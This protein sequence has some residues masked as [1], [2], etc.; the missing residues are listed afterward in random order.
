M[1]VRQAFL[2]YMLLLQ[3]TILMDELRITSTADRSFSW[4]FSVTHSAKISLHTRNPR[5]TGGL[6]K[7]IC[8][9]VP[10]SCDSGLSVTSSSQLGELMWQ[11]ACCWSGPPP[12]GALSEPH[13]LQHSTCHRWYCSCIITSSL[14]W[15]SNHRKQ[16]IYS[17]ASILL[18]KYTLVSPILSDR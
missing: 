17:E 3:V 12:G 16:K 14:Y 11:T 18:F 5:Q 8:C 7:Y 13:K 2:K 9:H 1:E 10:V 15:I 4:S 6:G